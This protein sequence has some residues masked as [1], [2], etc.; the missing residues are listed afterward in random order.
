MITEEADNPV[1]NIDIRARSIRDR[2]TSEFSVEENAEFHKDPSFAH[3][4]Q[5]IRVSLEHVTV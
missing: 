4:V 3:R 2:L 5:C 1:L